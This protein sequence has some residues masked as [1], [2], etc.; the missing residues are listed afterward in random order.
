MITLAPREVND[1]EASA[2]RFDRYLNDQNLEP[3]TVALYRANALRY[4]KSV[5]TDRPTGQDWDRFRDSLQAQLSRS[6]LNQYA[7]A[8]RAYHNIINT[9]III[10]RL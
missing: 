1:Y 5:H 8:A 7:Y 2:A 10:K 6:T 9:Q 3:G 4:L